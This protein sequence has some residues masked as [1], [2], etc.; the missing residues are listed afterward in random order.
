LPVQDS[1]HVP[2]LPNYSEIDP[3]PPP[4]K[5]EDVIVEGI[6]ENDESEPC[7]TDED[8]TLPDNPDHISN[9]SQNNRELEGDALCDNNRNITSDHCR[10]LETSS[11]VNIRN[12]SENVTILSNDLMQSN[13]NENNMILVREENDSERQYIVENIHVDTNREITQNEDTVVHC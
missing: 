11:N 10:L 12:I 13:T 9:V 6:D 1:V 7:V 8:R 3:L 5:Y 2:T 4:P